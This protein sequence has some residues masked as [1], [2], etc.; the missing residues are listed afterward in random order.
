MRVQQSNQLLPGAIFQT[1]WQTSAFQEKVLTC[2][3]EKQVWVKELGFR[4]GK[5]TRI[6][7]ARYHNVGK[8]MSFL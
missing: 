2:F 5:A 8:S 6:C 3:S 7:R 4:F 1:A